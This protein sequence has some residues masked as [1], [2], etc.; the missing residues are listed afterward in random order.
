[1]KERHRI[2]FCTPYP[3]PLGGG[4]DKLF[5][6]S[7]PVRVRWDSTQTFLDNTDIEFSNT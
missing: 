5:I 4:N 7:I 3:Q 1:M 2:E 6:E